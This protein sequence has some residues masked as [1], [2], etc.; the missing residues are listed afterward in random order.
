[1]FL[2]LRCWPQSSCTPQ[3]PGGVQV[4]EGWQIA[5]DHLLSRTN[6]TLQSALVLST[7]SS[8]LHGDG[9]GEDELQP[10]L[11]QQ[12]GGIEV[13]H[14]QL[15]QKVDPLLGFLGEGAEQQRY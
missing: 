4:L 8:I 3:V 2:G 10:H 14:P 5:T 11:H 9:E 1:M 6:D 15:L 12:D 13:H 7:G